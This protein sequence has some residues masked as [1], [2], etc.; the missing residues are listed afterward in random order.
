MSRP[1]KFYT[2]IDLNKFIIL[3][4]FENWKGNYPDDYSDEAIEDF[5][6]A[7][8][9]EAMGYNIDFIRDTLKEIQ[10]RY[11]AEKLLEKSLEASNLENAL[12]ISLVAETGLRIDEICSLKVKDIL[13]SDSVILVS[14]KGDRTRYCSMSY[15]VWKWLN[16]YIELNNLSESDYLFSRTNN[17]KYTRQTIYNKL[18]SLRGRESVS[19]DRMRNSFK[20]LDLHD[21]EQLTD[22]KDE[23][24]L[25]ESMYKAITLIENE[26]CSIELCNAIDNLIAAYEEMEDDD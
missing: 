25:I 10:Y 18:K 19:I 24:Q 22:R 14:G 3:R 13:F 16:N 9:H 15:K 21:M 4:G 5:I 17:Q 6:N 26:D 12:I 20:T 11:T 2:E 8:P 1:L 7:Y 23:L